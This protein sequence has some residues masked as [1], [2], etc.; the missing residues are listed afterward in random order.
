M[1]T[2]KKLPVQKHRTSQNM[3]YTK[4]QPTLRNTYFQCCFRCRKL[5]VFLC[6]EYFRETLIFFLNFHTKHNFM[7]MLVKWHS[8]SCVRFFMFFALEVIK[9][10]IGNDLSVHITLNIRHFFL[11]VAQGGETVFSQCLFKTGYI[12]QTSACY[13][14]I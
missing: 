7:E 11:L 5:A 14:N 3:E 4:T 8:V 9:G 6:S 2:M 1:G 10:C 13:L 12:Y